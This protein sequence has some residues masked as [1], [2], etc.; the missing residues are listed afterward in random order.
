MA[1]S[2][3]KKAAEPVASRD[4]L[5]T[6]ELRFID[7]FLIDRDPLAAG[8]RAGVSRLNL[9]RRVKSWM[10]DPRIVRAI[11]LK[12]D[13][14]DL[15]KMISPQRIMAGFID[16]AFNKDAPPAARNT[17][18]RELASMKKMYGDE[19]KDN[20]GSGVIMVPVVGS[21]K[22]WNTLAMEAQQKLK[23]DVRG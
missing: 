12:T 11:Q 9:K 20:K 2:P 23:E 19:D 8:L 14:T 13:T 22:D 4:D 7:E 5:D 21:L 1:R 15:D 16:V 10:D 18:L 3:T 6:A 17:A